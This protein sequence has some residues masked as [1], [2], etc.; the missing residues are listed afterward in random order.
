MLR[1]I[2][3][4]DDPNFIIMNLTREE[5]VELL[6]MPYTLLLFR[7]SNNESESLFEE[8]PDELYFQ[9]YSQAKEMYDHLTA[10]MESEDTPVTRFTH[11]MLMKYGLEGNP[12][13][14]DCLDEWDECD[15]GTD[16]SYPLSRGWLVTNTLQNVEF[17]SNKMDDALYPLRL[18]WSFDKPD[19][20]QY[21][22]LYII[23]KEEEKLEFHR[24][25][26]DPTQFYKVAQ[27]ENPDVEYFKT[28]EAAKYFCDKHP[29]LD[30]GN[31]VLCDEHFTEVGYY[32]Q[33][34]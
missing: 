17:D 11:I 15:G 33:F 13:D 29:D 2:R 12:E 18:D 10:T 19:H 21:T 8:E 6:Q 30:Y 14:G 25:P 24:Q 31:I 7:T 32:G 28:L 3:K 27:A 26:F 1:F 23:E 9:E 16:L 22:V 4:N 34:S 20:D 5:Q